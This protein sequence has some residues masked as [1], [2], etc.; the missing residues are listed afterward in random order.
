MIL[1]LY[2]G[3]HLLARPLPLAE[4]YQV[5]LA[6]KPLLGNLRWYVLWSFGLPEM[7]IDYIGPGLHINPNLF[8]FY[9]TSILITVV[10]VLSFIILILISLFLIL[11]KRIFQIL[12]E[13]IFWFSIL[14]FG[15]A[16]LPVVSFQWHKFSYY[17]TVAHFGFSLFLAFLLSQLFKVINPKYAGLLTLSI[18]LIFFLGNLN[19]V[20]LTHKTNWVVSR[21]KLAKSILDDLKKNHSNISGDSVIYFSNDPNSPKINPQWGFSSTQAYVALSGSNAVQVLY[22]NREIKVYYEDISPPPANLGKEKVIKIVAPA[23][24]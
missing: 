8:K 9:R 22:K 1:L 20:K 11:R 3:F 19:T 4:T 18:L 14:W 17:L 21:A 6:P 16:V 24:R 12:R 7:L 15:V 2:A 13:R 5:N 10:W 23:Q